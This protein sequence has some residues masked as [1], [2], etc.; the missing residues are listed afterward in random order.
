MTGICGIEDLWVSV[1]VIQVKPRKD[2]VS[3]WQD[4]SGRKDGGWPSRLIDLL[5]LLL[6]RVGD[7]DDSRQVEDEMPPRKGSKRLDLLNEGVWARS[8][9]WGCEKDQENVMEG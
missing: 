1:R 6:G 9:M 2:G 8:G 7:G 3:P 4:R 5:R